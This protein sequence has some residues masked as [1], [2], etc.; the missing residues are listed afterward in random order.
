MLFKPKPKAQGFCWQL[1]SQGLL[2]LTGIITP[3]LLAGVGWLV[4]TLP[5]QL[6]QQETQLNHVIKNQEELKD[7]IADHE[8]MLRQQEL[9]LTREE[10]R[11]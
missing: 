2:E 9:R 7:K 8:L 1:V 11:N 5:Q 3:F 6:Q 4:F 10:L